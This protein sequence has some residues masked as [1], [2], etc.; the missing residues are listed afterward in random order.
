MDAGH[1]GLRPDG[2][3][4][5]C[6]TMVLF[7]IGRSPRGDAGGENGG[8][9]ARK[10]ARQGGDRPGRHAA[11]RGSPFGSL[12]HPVFSAQQIFPVRLEPYR[13]GIDEGLILQAFMDDD[14]GH[15]DQGD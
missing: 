15:G 13:V 2:L 4:R 3:Q 8:F 7:A 5:R 1:A 14:K 9:A 12:H 6:R 10:L 11:D